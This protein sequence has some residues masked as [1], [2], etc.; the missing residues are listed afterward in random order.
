MVL[1]KN[2][3]EWQTVFHLKRVVKCLIQS[4]ILNNGMKMTVTI[5]LIV[6]VAIFCKN[7]R[8]SLKNAFRGEKFQKVQYDPLQLSTK[9][10]WDFVYG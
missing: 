8:G 6:M 7:G 3:I 2:W 4:L 5:L 9:E 1:S 10:H